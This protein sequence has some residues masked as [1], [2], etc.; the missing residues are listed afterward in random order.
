MKKLL[1][2]LLALLMVF[3][4]AACNNNSGNGGNEGGNSGSET[5]AED[6]G[7][8]I[9][10]L[11]PHA[12]DQSYFD[13]IARGAKKVND[14]DNG[15]SVEV[16]ECDPESAAEE[17]NW[18]GWFDDVCEDGKY[19]LVVSG[20]SSYEQFLYQACEKYPDQK[21]MNFD[22]SNY[23]ESGVPANCYC[24]TYALDD[25]GYAVGAL[26]A[27]L[28]KTGTV[29]VVVG[30]DNQAMNQF[31]GGWCQ[32]LTD[33]GVKYVI[34]YPGSF[35]D[36]ALGKET[37]KAMIDKGADVIWQVAGGLGN[38]VIEACSE[39]EGVW[40]VGVDQDQYA[41]FKD[42]NPAW[43]KVI[44]TSALK[45]SDVMFEEVAKMVA[46]GSFASKLGT[47]EQ[48]TLAMNGVGIAENEYYLA[49]VSEDIRNTIK[50]TLDKAAS[51]EVTVVDTMEWTPEE[52]EANW[53]AIKDANRID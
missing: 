19:D 45:N 42:S 7:I 49:N 33:N 34:S 28:T 13:T 36:T 35:R 38:G 10:V 5:P 4:L 43:A 6:D 27:A 30:M 48:W 44:I 47:V 52:Y 1:S 3:T 51:G 12:G 39:A 40:C 31:I 17:S 41:Q 14:E 20:N 16:F 24:V 2:V 23:P 25:L 8:N 11:I 21:F 26:S 53:P 50:E 29:G 22:C 46:D 18:M 32:V 15:I 37:T 9:A